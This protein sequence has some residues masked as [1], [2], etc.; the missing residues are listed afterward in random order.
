MQIALISDIHGNTVALDAVL[1]EIRAM[2]SDLVVV[3]LGDIATGGP[4]PGGAVDRIA[5]LGCISVRGNTDAG[6]VDMPVWWREPTSIGLPADAVPGMEITVWAADRLT[7]EQQA[8]LAHLPVTASVDLGPAGQLLAFHGSPRSLDE[9][10]TAMTP[11]EDLDE[12]FA[13]TSASVLA[14]GHTHVALTRRHAGRTILNP[15]SVGM[16]F[17]DYGYA[18]GVAGLDHA[19]YAIVTVDGTRL[20]VE[21]RQ[22]EVD[23]NRLARSV[24]RSEMPHAEWW[25]AQR[26]RGFS[27][28]S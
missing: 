22:L 4:D 17:S 5:E 12:M 8:F 27:T 9:L 3:C 25:I 18:G 26:S 10:I 6:A 15:G 13:G 20:H 28:E 2:G 11:A 19:E 16:P 7:D 21:H 1:A 24:A 14:G 23:A